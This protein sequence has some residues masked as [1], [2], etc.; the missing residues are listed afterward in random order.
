MAESKR[1]F[2]TGC[3]MSATELNELFCNTDFKHCG[4]C[5]VI[6]R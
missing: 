4:Y 3:C 5:G 6:L 1:S 2:V